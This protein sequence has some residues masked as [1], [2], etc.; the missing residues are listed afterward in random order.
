MNYTKPKVST[1]GDAMTVIEQVGKPPVAPIEPA[2]DPTS[3]P[4]YDLDE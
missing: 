3:L 4:A 1:I 2:K